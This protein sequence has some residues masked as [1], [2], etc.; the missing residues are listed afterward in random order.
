MEDQPTD[1]PDERDGFDVHRALQPAPMIATVEASGR[2]V[3]SCNRGCSRV[4]NAVIS[5]ESSSAKASSLGIANN[6]G[7]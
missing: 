5:I 2:A 7:S 1:L 4:R 3:P 6:D